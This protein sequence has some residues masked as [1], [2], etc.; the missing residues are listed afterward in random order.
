MDTK[1]KEKD[2]FIEIVNSEIFNFYFKELYRTVYDKRES[3]LLSLKRTGL[4]LEY[5]D[6]K[7]IESVI[8]FKIITDLCTWTGTINK[9]DICLSLTRYFKRRRDLNC[10]FD[11]SFKSMLEAF[12]EI[13]KTHPNSILS[14]NQKGTK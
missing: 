9:K 7:H 3:K 13:K 8:S 10:N 5:I 11:Y 4:S 1:Y 12:V 2:L 14:I 6:N